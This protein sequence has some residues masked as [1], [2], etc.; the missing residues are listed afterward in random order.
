MSNLAIQHMSW[1]ER[2]RA[3]EELWESLSKD[4]PRLESPGW[5]GD[6]LRE[7]IETLFRQSSRI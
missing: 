3:M 6:A 5:H 4:E 1:E 7:R 2:L